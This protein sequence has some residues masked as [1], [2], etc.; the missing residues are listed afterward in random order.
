MSPRLLSHVK[1]EATL[2]NVMSGEFQKDGLER[3]FK[4]PAPD[5]ELSNITLSQNKKYK[6]T[7]QTAEILFVLDGEVCFYDDHS[8]LGLK[9]G[10]SVFVSAHCSYQLSTSSTAIV[11]KA[12][13]PV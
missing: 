5:F 7:T 11:Y 1:F 2:P 10:Q 13:T 8:K 3:I 9:R 4:S 12:T 6:K